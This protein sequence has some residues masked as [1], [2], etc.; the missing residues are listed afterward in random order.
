M[1]QTV[2]HPDTQSFADALESSLN[3]RKPEEGE[4]LKGTIVSINGDDVFVSYGGPTEAV[5]ASSELEGKEVGD[6]IEATVVGTAPVIR[7]SYKLAMKRASIQSLKQARDN[8]IPVVGKR[9]IIPR[10]ARI[11]RNVKVGAD[12]RTSDF[13]KRVIKSGESVERRPSGETARSVRRA[14]AVAEG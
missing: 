8:G 11:G 12:V 14:K 1:S 6:T 3:F 10:G 2:E 9:A 4:L 7:L 13:V 5:M